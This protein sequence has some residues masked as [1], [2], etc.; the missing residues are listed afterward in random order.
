VHRQI[1][2][3]N[4]VSDIVRTGDWME[5]AYEVGLKRSGVEML[6]SYTDLLADVFNTEL[7]YIGE[8]DTDSDSSIAQAARV[9][10]RY[11]HTLAFKGVSDLLSN[12]P[13]KVACVDRIFKSEK[14]WRSYYATQ[15]E[16]NDKCVGLIVLAS[17]RVLNSG[18]AQMS[19]LKLVK[20]RLAFEYERQVNEAETRRLEEQL[21]QS[22]KMESLGTLAGG[23][24]HDFNNI[25]GAILGYAG[26]LRL[27]LKNNEKL[28]KYI[29]TIERSTRRASEL[30]KQL[31]G[32]A[33]GGKTSVMSVDFNR[34]CRETVELTKKMIE[35]NVVVSL[36]LYPDLPAVE[37]D[38]SQLSQVMM[39]LA[40]NARDAIPNGGSLRISTSVVKANRAPGYN[41]NLEKR[42]YVVVEVA[43][44]GHGIS[45]G[46][47]VRIFEPFFTTKP[48]G[49][50]TGLGLSMVY[51]IIKNH[52]GEIDV[53]SQVNKGTTFR[54]YLPVS[55]QKISSRT[56]KRDGEVEKLVS[57]KTCL[58]VDDESEF[59]EMLSDSL[60]RFGFTVVS[61][62]SGEK[63]LE[64]L[65]RGRTI[66]LV[67][68]DMIMP[69]IDGRETYF[70][71]KKIRP[72]LP[73]F[74]S[75]GYSSEGKV[76]DIM[77]NGGLGVL[78]KPFALGELKPC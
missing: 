24:A 11:L 35:K 6:E 63:A 60:A 51:G 53:N 32:F 78:H 64:I 45:K 20:Q 58:V 16:V 39:N 76:Q 65:R 54:I 73:V 25:L 77:D 49:K 26:L 7:V 30:T 59:R 2:F 69:G 14:G 66:D 3:L 43:D 71:M 5:R 1:L 56:P 36:D 21:R 55:S 22:Q 13:E 33:R 74:V 31:L 52:G 44:S 46:N 57:D 68:L 42:E 19:I 17:E 47:L 67:V 15:I 23:V 72:G 50:G 28:T 37:G 10:D 38:E 48:K 70:E 75:T 9:G 27:E 62:E 8:C 4:D 41:P 12:D 34:I 40:I 29:E 18:R 61:A